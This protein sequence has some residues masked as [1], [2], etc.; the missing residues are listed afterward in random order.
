MV[1]QENHHYVPVLSLI[2]TTCHFSIFDWGGAIH[3]AGFNIHDDPLSLLHILI[4]MTYAPDYCLG[5]DPTIQYITPEDQNPFLIATT[6]PTPTSFL[7]TAESDQAKHSQP[8]TL[9]HLLR[10]R[11]IAKQSEVTQTITRNT[12]SSKSLKST[13][14]I[15]SSFPSFLGGNLVD[16][17]LSA[18]DRPEGSIHKITVNNTKYEIKGSV[19]HSIMIYGRAMQCWYVTLNGEVFL[20]KDSWVLVTRVPSEVDILLIAQDAGVKGIPKLV[21]WEDVLVQGE[22]DCCNN[23]CGLHVSAID[24]V[25]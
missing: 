12:Q 23:N 14:I 18:A 9:T 25:H 5:Y 8:S 3:L 22:L 15:K 11:P 10:Q 1:S 20:I 16:F 6:P 24:Q 21:D 2:G 17:Q 19:F 7:G 4:G 13:S